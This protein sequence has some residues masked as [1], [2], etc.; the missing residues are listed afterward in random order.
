MDELLNTVHDFYEFYERVVRDKHFSLRYV[1]P[2]DT[3]KSFSCQR[4]VDLSRSDQ[5]NSNPGEMAWV[6]E[7]T[8][9]SE[10]DYDAYLA[11]QKLTYFLKQHGQNF[12]VQG[13]RL[14][15]PRREGLQSI[16]E[17]LHELLSEKL[18]HRKSLVLTDPESYFLK[19][20]APVYAS[21]PALH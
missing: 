6:I 7:F 11:R 18:T 14:S 8:P 12:I 16:V 5:V 2:T 19:T 10:T 3:A 20:D 17:G 15:T 21:S 13:P 4:R 1:Y 9:V